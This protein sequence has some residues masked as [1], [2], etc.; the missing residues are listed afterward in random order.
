MG[1]VRRK[2][3]ED[4]KIKV[5]MQ[6]AGGVLT[7]SQAA[8]KYQIS[9]GLVATWTR[10]FGNGSGASDSSGVAQRPSA[11]ERELES[12]NQLLKEK[13]ADLFMQV[14]LL[15]KADTWMTQRRNAS[16]SIVTKSN[17]GRYKKGA[18]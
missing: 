2:F 12:E 7:I 14:E 17:L 16:S 15:K 18:K 4:F 6:V 3:A 9:T 1:R 11:R 5:A 13:L 10:T 8:R